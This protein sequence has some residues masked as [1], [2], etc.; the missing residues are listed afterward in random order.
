[1]D[2]QE[3]PQMS[4]DVVVVGAGNAAMSA[5]LSARAAGASVLV[6][7]RAPVEARGGNSAFTGGAFRVAYDG[8]DDI[9]RIADLSDHERET[10]DFGSYSEAQF[11]HD[12]AEMSGYRADP[13]LLYRLVSESKNALWWLRDQGVRFLPSYG[14]QS[15]RV[16]GK[17][18]FWG[19]LTIEAAGGGQGLMDA[20]FARAERNEVEIRY[21]HEVVRL[22]QARGGVC[23]VVARTPEGECEIAAGAVVLA[24]GGFHANAEWRTRYLGPGWENARV[25]GSRY[26]SGGGIRAALDAGAMSHGNWSGCHSVFFDARAEPFGV[27]GVL[28]QQKNYFSLG[29]VVNTCGERFFDEGADFR[30]YIYSL[31]GARILRQPGGY[32]WQIFDAQTLALLPDEYR[33]PRAAKFQADTIEELIARLQG[34]DGQRLAQTI[35]EY[36]AACDTAVAFNPAVKD[37]K[38]T[39]GLVIDKS[40]WANPIVTPP[41]TAFEVTCGITCTFAGVAIGED[42][43]VQGQD[44]L[45]MPGLYACGEMVGGLYYERYPGGAGLTSGTVFGRVAGT[46]AAAHAAGL[47]VG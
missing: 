20:L 33:T 1:V 35:A 46:A 24:A 41:F 22:V 28:N 18:V 30:N 17:A 32:G 45:P 13:E 40:N 16:D 2:Y 26:N 8:V 29:M 38:A 44:G 43:G 12:L 23:G 15:F 3:V 10:S 39:R 6:L 11:L 5:A 31:M 21:R 4:W 34:V 25:R 42:A 27:V 7:E 47:A 14:R 19:G 37:G 36:N 9:A